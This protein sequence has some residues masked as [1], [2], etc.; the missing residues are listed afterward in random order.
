MK[1]K[2]KAQIKQALK[3]A[4]KKQVKKNA[5]NSRKTVGKRALEG[6][7]KA[8]EKKAQKGAKTTAEQGKENILPFHF[9]PGQSGNLKGRPKGPSIVTILAKILSKKIEITDPFD[10]KKSKKP[11][12]EVIALKLVAA[13]MK[14][15][16]KSIV[17]IM[18][19]MD[20]K[21]KLPIDLSTGSPLEVVGYKI[22]QADILKH[23][24][25]LNDII[26]KRKNDKTR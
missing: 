20:G 23:S 16:R 4:A 10:K 25:M 17:E 22:S 2:T 7:K 21:A 26:R 6:T 9:K 19:R 14:G 12:S 11:V 18:D 1:P 3:N 8:P 5:T 15:D 13:A 24:S